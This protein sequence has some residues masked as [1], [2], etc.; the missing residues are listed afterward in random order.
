[1]LH[2]R[3]T[4]FTPFTTMA[5]SPTVAET[6]TKVV[7]KTISSSTA[8]STNRAAAQGGILEHG[9]PSKYDPKNPIIIFIIQVRSLRFG[10][11]SFG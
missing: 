11:D 9:D 8:T 2:Y 5:A 4:S 6:V 10:H 3:Q 7:T 1:M